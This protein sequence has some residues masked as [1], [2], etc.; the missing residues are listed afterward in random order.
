MSKKTDLLGE[1]NFYKASLHTHTTISDGRIEPEQVKKMY[2]DKGYS[3]V[4]FTDHEVLVS[5]R[6]LSDDNFLALTAYEIGINERG[7]DT[8]NPYKRIEV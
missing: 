2:K 5:H 4:A 8:L 1:G 3:I 6:E 7:I